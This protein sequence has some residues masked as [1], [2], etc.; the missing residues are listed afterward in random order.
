MTNA[1]DAQKEFEAQGKTEEP[2]QQKEG[3]SSPT[4][5]LHNSDG[6]NTGLFVVGKLLFTKA[7]T[8]YTNKDKRTYMFIEM[9][10]EKTNATA[11]VKDGTKYKDVP[12]K[13]GDIITVFAA[14]RLFNAASKVA[15]GSRLYASYTG[16]IIQKGKTI[17]THVVKSLPGTLTVAEKEYIAQRNKQ[18]ESTVDAEKAGLAEEAQAADALS[19]L[20][21]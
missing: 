12:V 7:I 4:I 1:I 6:E 11:T 10:L 21:D 5:K 9:V 18:K 8:K 2:S 15:P 20:E 16:A 13:A 19:Q 14:A 3:T 17:H